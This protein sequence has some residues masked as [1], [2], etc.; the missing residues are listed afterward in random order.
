MGMKMDE[1][2]ERLHRHDHCRY[3]AIGIH[4]QP[5]Y[6]ADRIVCRPAQPAQ[7]FT[8]ISEIHA[9]PL[10]YREYPLPVWN[11]GKHLVLKTVGKQQRP[12][13]VTR[14]TA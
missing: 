8:V 4:F 10:G 6:I 5:E 3:P 14:R 12:L 11:L 2:A 7:Q 1:I 13:L 9:Q